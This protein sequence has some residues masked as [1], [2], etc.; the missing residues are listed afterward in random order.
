MVWPNGYD[1]PPGEVRRHRQLSD[2]PSARSAGLSPAR[3]LP[4][5][6]SGRLDRRCRRRVF[7]RSRRIVGGIRWHLRCRDHCDLRPNYLAI[8]RW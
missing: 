1:D 4:K 8:D 7:I 5:N 6:P 2:V 3:R